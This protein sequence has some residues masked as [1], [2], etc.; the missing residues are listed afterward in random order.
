MERIVADVHTHTLA[1]GHAYGTI[2][3]MAQA[4]AERRLEILGITEHAPG[5]PGAPDALYYCNLTAVPRMLYGVHL[6][7]GCEI[8]VLDD[9]YLSLEQRWIDKLDYAIVGL[10]ALCY[11]D[12]GRLQNT[13]NL[14]RCMQNAKV[15]LVSHPDDDH[16]PLD[17][18]E[19]VRA[20]KECHTALEVNNSSFIKKDR[21]WNCLEN[22]ETM[23]RYCEQFGVPVILNSD[24]H[25]PSSVGEVSLAWEF[26]ENLEFDKGLI[27]NTDTKKLLPFLLDD[28]NG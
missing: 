18:K 12:A 9:G 14:I 5:I 23:L 25:D 10:H 4:A 21:R 3:E 20:A 19:L 2:R 15:R 7:H 13:R 22:Y 26:V 28:I 24:A 6:L 11:Q 27:L 8:N 1:S 17:Y 16:I